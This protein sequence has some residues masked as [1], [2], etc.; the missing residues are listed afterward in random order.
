M[1]T[2][3]PELNAELAQLVNDNPERRPQELATAF[4]EHH[5]GFSYPGVLQRVVG[6]QGRRGVTRFNDHP[7]E[8][9]YGEANAAWRLVD[10]LVEALVD[11]EDDGKLAADHLEDFEDDDPDEVEDLSNETPYWEFEFLPGLYLSLTPEEK[12]DTSFLLGIGTDD[13]LFFEAVLPNTSIEEAKRAALFAA[14]GWLD[15]GQKALQVAQ[16]FPQAPVMEDV[17]KLN[18]RWRTPRAGESGFAP[19]K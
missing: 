8:S 4:T 6:L 17:S 7:R 10:P 2:W 16:S 12:S 15:E 5:E 14:M 3:T 19:K 13:E 11:D 1:S 9:D 18:D